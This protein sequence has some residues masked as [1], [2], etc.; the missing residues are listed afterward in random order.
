MVSHGP[1][2]PPPPPPPPRHQFLQKILYRPDRGR[3][4]LVPGYN[5][6]LVKEYWEIFERKV[7]Y[8][9]YKIWLYAS[10]IRRPGSPLYF[11]PLVQILPGTG[12]FRKRSWYDV[13]HIFLQFC[14]TL[15]ARAS[16]FLYARKSNISSLNTYLI[17]CTQNMKHTVLVEKVTFL[18]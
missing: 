18:A 4:G 7:T 5:S 2:S 3:Y 10:I 1:P 9:L 17:P 16:K 8:R 13:L 6:G 11:R 15:C 14:N 12:S